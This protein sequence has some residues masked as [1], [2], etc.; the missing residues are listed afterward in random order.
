[1]PARKPCLG[2]R[3]ES[4][5]VLA[6]TEAGRTVDQIAA[7]TGIAKS[8]V[9]TLM[10]YA[11]RRRRRNLPA[12]LHK[13]QRTVCVPIDILDRLAPAASERGI[14]VDA[15]VRWLLQEIAEAGL[16]GAVLDDG[17]ADD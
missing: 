12:R 2:Y 5:A 9:S 16:V 6:L 7:M 4:D 17:A 8:R 15:L 3:S 13:H 10:T 1:M 11:R 14:S